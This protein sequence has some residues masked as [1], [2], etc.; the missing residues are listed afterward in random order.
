MDSGLLKTAKAAHSPTSSFTWVT[1][2]AN[3]SGESRVLMTLVITSC[4]H[5]IAGIRAST[6]IGCSC[7][8]LPKLKCPI[9]VMKHKQNIP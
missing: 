4:L 2:S 8:K 1:K 6:R 3:T 7:T 9:Y 5:Q